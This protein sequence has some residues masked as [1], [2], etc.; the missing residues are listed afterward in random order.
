VVFVED[1]YVV[2]KFATY[3]TDNALGRSGL[4]WAS[5]CCALWVPPRGFPQEL[6]I[7]SILGRGVDSQL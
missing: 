6:D 4:P 7:M 5:E 2:E 1:D 3:G